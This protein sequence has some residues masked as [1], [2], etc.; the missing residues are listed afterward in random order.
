[1]GEG[2]RISN[3]TRGVVL[4]DRARWAAN[5]WARFRGLMLTER[6][7]EGEA[8]VIEPCNSIHMFF[9][10]YPIDVIFT[11]REHEVV[12]VVE[13]I[14]PWRMTRFFRGARAAVELPAGT[15]QR[16]QTVRGDRLAFEAAE[17]A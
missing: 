15:V 2:F 5:P 12:G 14:R 17:R 11:S 9:M 10:R 7:P 1:M 6:L 3:S 4:A 13:S 8:L 16:S